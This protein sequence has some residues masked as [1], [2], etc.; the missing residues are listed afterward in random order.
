[1]FV[2]GFPH[3]PDGRIIWKSLFCHGYAFREEGA[4]FL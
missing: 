1:M 3:D 2:A 4:T